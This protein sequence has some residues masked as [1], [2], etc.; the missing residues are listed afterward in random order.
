M[1]VVHLIAEESTA[2]GSLPTVTQRE[3]TKNELELGSD[4]EACL[5]SHSAIL[6]P[7]PGERPSLDILP[8]IPALPNPA[9]LIAQVLGFVLT[10]N[11]PSKSRSCPPGIHY[12]YFR[13]R[14]R[15]VPKMQGENSSHGSNVKEMGATEAPSL[16]DKVAFRLGLDRH[17]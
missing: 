11:K 3:V 16:V 8:A 14:Q 12:A 7:F 1:T 17:V 13:G 5:L 2:L 15:C 9:N 6:P 4:C 10:G